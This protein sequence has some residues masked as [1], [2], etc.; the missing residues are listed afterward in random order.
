[1]GSFFGSAAQ[2]SKPK[3]KY[4][5][6][7]PITFIQ[8]SNKL[9]ASILLH[10]SFSRYRDARLVRDDPNI[11]ESIFNCISKLTVDLVELISKLNANICIMSS[12]EVL[13]LPLRKIP[14]STCTHKYVKQ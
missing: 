13:L 5:F 3:R 7:G 9:L 8:T 10:L 12:F 4:I 11:N 2:W 1:M 6:R 14:L